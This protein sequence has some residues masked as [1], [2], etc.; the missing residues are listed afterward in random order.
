MGQETKHTEAAAAAS[1]NLV[2]EQTASKELERWLDAKRVPS[3]KR[4]QN[5]QVL[6]TLKAA[7]QDG[8]LI[9]TDTGQ[10]SVKLLFPIGNND[11]IKKL[12]FTNRIKA[13]Q[14]R[15]MKVNDDA[16]DTMGQVLALVA[17]ATNNSMKL[18]GELDNED[19]SLIQSIAVFFM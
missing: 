19:Y 4:E 12:N 1:F 3:R 6:E 17:A 11:D 13:K 9:V 14:V 2:D 10:I 8:R 18:L 7:I 15:K 16:F 5:D